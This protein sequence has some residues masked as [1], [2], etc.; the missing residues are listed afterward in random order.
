MNIGLKQSVRWLFWLIEVL[1]FGLLGWIGYA[2]DLDKGK[3]GPLGTVIDWT[4]ANAAWLIF[5]LAVCVIVARS[6]KWGLAEKTPEAK[7]IDSLIDKALDDFREKCFPGILQNE[8]LDNNRV[9]IFRH[10]QRRWWIRPGR[11]LFWP[12]GRGRWPWSG[13]LEVAYRSGHATQS[14]GTVFLAPDDAHQ[15]EGIAGEAW[16]GV[17]STRVRNLPDLSKIRYIGHMKVAWLRWRESRGSSAGEV[18]N[19]ARAR[20]NIKTYAE[21]TKI[22]E[23]CVWQ[24]IRRKRK[25]PISMCGVPIENRNGN[26]VG[27]VVLDSCNSIE[28]IETELRPFRTAFRRLVQSLQELGALE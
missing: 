23:R 18:V 13:W 3:S 14:K 21:V 20:D 8:P 11:S 4:G 25:L 24:R 2:L 5:L 10:V 9:T 26:L 27:A 12:W 22:S 15:A 7:I 16:R 6:V 19:Y 1:S 17:S 28:C